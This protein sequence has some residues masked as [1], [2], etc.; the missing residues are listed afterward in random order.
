MSGLAKLVVTGNVVRDV[1]VK[2][3]SNGNVMAKTS[4][5][6][7]QFGRDEA[8]FLDVTIWGKRGEAAS[9]ILRKGTPVTLSG[10]LEVREWEAKDG[11]KRTTIGISV[12]DFAV[13]GGGKSRQETVDV[14]ASEDSPF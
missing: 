7:N 3:T 12:D 8:L 1:E 6:V 4:V 13:H 5:A 2:T 14:A 10:N 9:K 11:T